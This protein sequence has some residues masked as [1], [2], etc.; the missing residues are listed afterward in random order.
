MKKEYIDAIYD[1]E[2]VKRQQFVTDKGNYD[3]IL[4]RKDSE[5]YFYKYLNRTMVECCNLSKANGTKIV[6]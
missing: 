1:G 4:V 2:I 3:V 5:I 6:E